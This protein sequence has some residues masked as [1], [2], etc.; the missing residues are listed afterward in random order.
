MDELEGLYAWGNKTEKEK[1][2]MLTPTHGTFKKSN[3]RRQR[4]IKIAAG[5][6]RGGNGKSSLKDAK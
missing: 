4:I 2:Y 5:E 3:M 1:Y 6:S